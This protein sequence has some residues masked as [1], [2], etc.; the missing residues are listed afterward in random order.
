MSGTQTTIDAWILTLTVVGH[1]VGDRMMM[2]ANSMMTEHGFDALLGVVY[3]VGHTIVEEF[4]K[5][6]AFFIAFHIN[7]PRS[8]RAI[9]T[10]GV[11]V[12]VGFAFLENFGYFTNTE[13]SLVMSFIIR[14]V[15]HGLFTGLIALLF[16]FGYFSQMRWIDGGAQKSIGS[17]FIRYGQRVV[18]IFWTLV[19]IVLAAF[20]HSGINTFAALGGQSIAII[21]MMMIW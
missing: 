12:G 19:G 17:W 16:A 5:F 13:M 3:L 21:V 8:I 9:V 1:D 2:F 7:K 15:G 11:V 4:I 6:I 18:Q 10:H 20:V 14:S